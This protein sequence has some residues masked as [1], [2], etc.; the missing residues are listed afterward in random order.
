ML[1]G[2]SL[3]DEATEKGILY[4]VQIELNTTCNWNCV[5]CYLE[6]HSEDGL[7]KNEL[8]RIM[9]ELRDLGVFEIEFTGGEI[10][11]RRDTLDILRYARKKGFMV[12]IYSNI[13]YLKD[14]KIVDELA[15]IGISK[16][17]CTIFS[18]NNVIHD[19][20]TQRKGSLQS[21]L[22]AAQNI[23]N[24]GIPLEVKTIIMNDNAYD[25]ADV[26]KFCK[27]MGFSFLAT[28]TVYAA[29]NNYVDAEKLRVNEKTHIE[30]VQEVDSVRKTQDNTDDEAFICESSRHHLSI[31]YNGDVQPC[32]NLPLVLGNVRNE[33]ILSIWDN[34]DILHIIQN[35]KWKDLKECRKCENRKICVRCSG[36]AYVEC[37]DVLARDGS[38]CY[39]TRARAK[40][41]EKS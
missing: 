21:V 27:K 2:K 1:K 34:S 32:S 18:M 37:G 39:V 4:D 28:T 31:R 6:N 29:R 5:H 24:A 35:Y 15:Q 12:N 17:S 14:M 38:A 3:I 11:T 8:F 25:F 13:S 40:A 22:Q 16:I 30:I 19:K 26:K 7:K 10:F 20:I 9:D 33:S 23:S 36:I 41:K